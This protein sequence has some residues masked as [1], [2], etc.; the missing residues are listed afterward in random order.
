M[1]NTIC[2]DKGRKFNELH[3]A[4][5]AS[6]IHRNNSSIEIWL[7]FNRGIS[8]YSPIFFGDAS[9]ATVIR[10]FCSNVCIFCFPVIGEER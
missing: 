6:V 3:K 4:A 8:C 9:E 5:T 7:S 1:L 10:D 2:R